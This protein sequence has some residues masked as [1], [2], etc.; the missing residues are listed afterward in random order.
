MSEAGYLGVIPLRPRP[1]LRIGRQFAN[2]GQQQGTFFIFGSLCML[3]GIFV[4]FFVPKIEGLVLERMDELF[5]VMELVK[6]LDNDSETGDT[7]L[8]SIREEPVSTKKYG[9]F[10]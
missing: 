4:W 5:G 6:Q 9:V 7:E 1:G 8:R 2:H 3:V 10:G